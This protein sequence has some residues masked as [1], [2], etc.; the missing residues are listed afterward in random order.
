M[1][2]IFL[3]LSFTLSANVWANG[4]KEIDFLGASITRGL[5]AAVP[6]ETRIEEHLVK[7]PDLATIK[8]NKTLFALDYFFVTNFGALSKPNADVEKLVQIQIQNWL[9]SKMNGT[10]PYDFVVVGLLPVPE[11]TNSITSQAQLAFL[12]S[13]RGHHLSGVYR[14]I[15]NCCLA[16]AKKVNRYLRSIANSPSNPNSKIYLFDL[17][18]VIEWYIARPGL[19]TRELYGKVDNIHINS[20]GQAAFYNIGLIPILK[21]MW[22]VQNL[23]DM[24]TTRPK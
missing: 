5:L 1:K 21:E 11:T 8:Q 18:S 24:P 14:M 15:N 22:G 6:L 7:E 12:N 3:I 10:E 9:K 20:R 23:E 17:T 19:N 4:I 16:N 2:L 13:A